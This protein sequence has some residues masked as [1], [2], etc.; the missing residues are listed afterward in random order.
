MNLNEP[1]TKK[2]KTVEGSELSNV[3]PEGLKI[4]NP[5]NLSLLANT[6][7]ELKKS[8]KLV[9]QL[10]F[11]TRKAIIVN[12]IECWKLTQITD[13][14][15]YNDN[16]LTLIVARQ[17]F[18]YDEV[19]KCYKHKRLEIL[20]PKSKKY[21]RT[22]FIK[23]FGN[24]YKY[25]FTPLLLMGKKQYLMQTADDKTDFY[26]VYHLQNRNNLKKINRLSVSTDVET[27]EIQ[28][29]RV[30]SP[31]LPPGPVLGKDPKEKIT[32]GKRKRK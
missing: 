8:D 6:A 20:I 16:Y 28:R 19:K 29:F 17:K 27:F 23:N 18:Y 5:D 1:D 15:I 10:C 12:G 25:K 3:I 24:P 9:E 30:P 32:L 7:L 14:R 26:E 21:N 11:M 2:T 13:K 4:T 22:E 31:R